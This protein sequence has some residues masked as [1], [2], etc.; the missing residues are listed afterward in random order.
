MEDKGIVCKHYFQVMLNTQEAKF[1]FNSTSAT[2]ESG[3]VNN[4]LCAID[5]EKQDSLK[6]RMN[7]LDKK[8]MYD[9]S[10]DEVES[11]DEFEEELDDV[12]DRNNEEGFQ[13]QNPKI[14]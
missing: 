12:D 1:H 9:S 5:K 2:I 10:D 6:Q 11:D 8:I 13:L 3:V 4:Y 14:R 7:I